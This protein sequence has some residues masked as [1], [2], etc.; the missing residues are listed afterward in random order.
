MHPRLPDEAGAVVRP[1]VRMSEVVHASR[2][3]SGFDVRKTV[4]FRCGANIDDARAIAEELQLWA[5]SAATPC[6]AA[7]HACLR[8][9]SLVGP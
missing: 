3:C 9:P 5:P 6:S 7:C 1:T 2:W 4:A 8:V